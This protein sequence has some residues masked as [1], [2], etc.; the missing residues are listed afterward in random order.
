[1][2]KLYNFFLL[3]YR[4]NDFAKLS[5]ARLTLN[6]CL[7][8]AL[9]SILYLV[10]ANLIDFNASQKVMLIISIAFIGLAFLLR[11]SVTLNFISFLY[12]SIS[13]VATDILVFNSGNIYSSILPWLSI[14]PLSANLLI[15]RK[16]AYFWLGICVTTVFVFAY[17]QDTPSDVVVQYDKNAEI[18]FYAIVYNGLIAII[19]VLSM[20]FQKAKDNV[21]TALEEKNDFISS[22]NYELKSKNDEILSQNEALLQQ[23]E[24]II[25]QREFIEI[26]NKELLVVQDELNSLIDKLTITQNA[27][28]S[29]EAENRSILEALYHT[30]LLVGELDVEGRFIKISQEAVKFLQM[31]EEE[32]LGKTFKEIG[33]KMKLSIQSNINQDEM[34]QDVVAGKNSSHEALLHINN[35]EFWLKENFFSIVNQKG[36]PTKVMIV[37]QDISTIKNQQNEIEALNTDLKENIWKIEKQ[38]GLLLSQRKEIETINNELKKSNEEIRNINLNLENHVK[39]RTQNLEVQNKQLSEYAYINAHLLRGPLCSILGLVHL[40]EHSKTNDVNSLIFHMKKSSQELQEVVDK[41]SKAIEKGTH[42]DRD[43]IFK[44]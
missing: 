22:I 8:T 33:G 39:E 25:A 26:K 32:I 35:N 18:W 7:V 40:L 29:R 15:N 31:S 17:I 6:F 34:W 24:E 27:L 30:E 5:Q 2:K 13:Y 4:Y 23:K 43:L 9:F 28:S 1:M 44:N 20:I 37:A 19:L 12:L 36:K 11:T 16:A 41:I 38:N 10:T 3:R 21:L 42:F 14:I